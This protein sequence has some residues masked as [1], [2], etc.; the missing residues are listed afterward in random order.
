MDN[1]DLRH[2]R[3]HS[4]IGQAVTEKL[5]GGY[6]A[7]DRTDG[8]LFK[9][10]QDALRQLDSVPLEKR[11]EYWAAAWGGARHAADLLADG[12]RAKAGKV[13]ANAR[14]LIEWAS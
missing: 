2:A 7:T 12:R 4:A 14:E 13:L 10:I 11:D 8:G 3:T 9:K 6:A 1:T 5:H